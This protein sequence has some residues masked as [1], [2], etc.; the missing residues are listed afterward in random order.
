MQV[1]RP[2]NTT[3]ISPG[4][5]KLGPRPR[6]P[7]EAVYRLRPKKYSFMNVR[8]RLVL[9]VM[10]GDESES[11]NMSERILITSSRLGASDIRAPGKKYPST[12]PSQ[13]ITLLN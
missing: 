3:M 12:K 8:H 9:A 11:R 5:V 13:S 6:L 7:S 10:Y 4:C 2:R 1:G